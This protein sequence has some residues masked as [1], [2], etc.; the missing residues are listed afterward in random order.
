M[1]FRRFYILL[2]KWE[3]E[4]FQVPREMS[5]STSDI[6]IMWSPLPL[7]KFSILV[8]SRLLVH[9][10]GWWNMPNPKCLPF[11]AADIGRL[12]LSTSWETFWLL[13]R[14]LHCV[15]YYRDGR[16][17]SFVNK[18][19]IWQEETQHNTNQPTTKDIMELYW[20][21]QWEQNYNVKLLN[22]LFPNPIIFRVVK[23]MML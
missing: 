1:Q 10:S 22:F 11:V 18:W 12:C 21:T 15:R 2:L 20:R 14:C 23:L 16:R 9:S 4:R 7:L 19:L 6:R 13:Q 17:S 5:A 8:W 3:L